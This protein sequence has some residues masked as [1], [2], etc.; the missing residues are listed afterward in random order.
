MCT[1]ILMGGKYPIFGRNMDLYYDI[2][3]S[4]VITPRNYLFEFRSAG[5]MKEHYAMIGMAMVWKGYPLY[6]E[7]AN[8]HGLAAAG[9]D[10]P[11]NAYYPEEMDSEKKNISPFE[12]IPWVLSQC[13]SIEDARILLCKTHITAVNFS[14]ELPLSPIHWHIADSSG[15]F[16]FEVTK[17][18]QIIYEDPADVMTNNPPFDFHLSN[19]AHYLNLTAENPE[20]KLGKIG[21]RPFSFGLGSFGLPG[22][23]SSASRFVKA[24]YLLRNSPA[25][26]NE[27]DCISQFFHILDSVAM[28]KGSV[29]TPDGN[30][31]MTAYSCGVDLKKGMYYYK[32]DANSR[33]NVVS[34]KNVPL[35]G[36][37]LSL[38]PL[39]NKQDYC[40]RN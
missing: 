21:V 6:F 10:F 34:I 5:E 4:V 31:D 20:N 28:V 25:C 30:F 37:E 39:E 3:S 17:R 27:S 35:D 12:F 38:Y 23:F 33:I 7:A 13:R 19:L 22:D 29:I 24:S 9:L 14:P 32:T 18:G 26:D 11:G 16:V 36:R 15:S 2:A 1:S 8:E 40:Y